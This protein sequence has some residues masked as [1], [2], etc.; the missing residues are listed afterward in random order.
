MESKRNDIQALRGI[1]I[2]LVV[3]FHA[4]PEML[5]GGYLGVQVFFAIAGY[6][7]ALHIRHR[8]A[9]GG[10]RYAAFV[11]ARLVRLAVPL[12]PVLAAASV[13]GHLLLTAT[14]QASLWAQ[15]AGAATFTA[16][17]VLWLQGGYFDQAAALKPLL[18]TWALAVIL[19]GALLL[20]VLLVVRRWRHA[21]AAVALCSFAAF[22]LV[23]AQ[24]PD[25]AY[26]LTPFRLWE[27]GIGMLLAGVAAPS[28]PN[29]TRALLSA[30]AVLL[31]AVLGISIQ[32]GPSA[33]AA[34]AACLATA[35]VLWLSPALPRA[36][37]PLVW[38]GGVSYALYLVHWP[39]LAFL[40]SLYLGAE[41]PIEATA[42]VV[43]ASI[44]MAWCLTRLAVR[45][46]ARTRP[47]T[48]AGCL[49]LTAITFAAYA[50]GNAIAQVDWQEERRPNVGLH[51]RCDFDGSFEPIAHCLTSARPQV[52]VWGDSVAMQWVEGLKRADTAGRGIAQATMSTCGPLLGVAPVYTGALGEPWARRCIAFNDSVLAWLRGQPQVQHVLLASIFAYHVERGQRLL[53]R[54]GKAPQTAQ[55]ALQALLRTVEEIRAIG[56]QV[57]VIAPVPAA[58]FD[59]GAC[60]ERRASGLPVLGRKDCNIERRDFERSAAPVID[61]LRRAEAA[62]VTV[63]RPADLLCDATACKTAIDGAPL[64]RDGT[65]I[66]YGGSAVLVPRLGLMT[67]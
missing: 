50:P 44:L 38:L 56:K 63:I 3:M 37:R 21:T 8:I 64:Y 15:L 27:S 36:L 4:K 33:L 42:G 46:N 45:T 48:A 19:Q 24:N 17:I 16:N 26:F 59:V 22:T 1:A 7:L 11:R 14:E 6:L 39:A 60:L 34:L 12:V 40:R 47:A 55:A 67:R 54:E 57:T 30:G 35:A 23:L 61:L 29:R 62:G 32:P 10:F 49:A 25:A 58:K 53:T 18:H 65:H 20:P 5:P 13:A 43:L 28:W 31:L 41:P 52:L 51:P 9:T 2:A 66:S